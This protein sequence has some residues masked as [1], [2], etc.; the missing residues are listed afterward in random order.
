M[1]HLSKLL[2]QILECVDGKMCQAGLY[3]FGQN[4]IEVNHKFRT[5]A[6]WHLEFCRV[7]IE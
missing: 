2:G 6:L 1:I 3:S 7:L 5:L 4:F